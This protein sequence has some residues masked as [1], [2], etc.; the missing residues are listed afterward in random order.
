MD[1]MVERILQEGELDQRLNWGWYQALHNGVISEVVMPAPGVFQPSGRSYDTTFPLDTEAPAADTLDER[2][3]GYPLMAATDTNNP[4]TL[5]R[6]SEE[7]GGIVEVA[8][9]Y[10]HDE[11]GGIVDAIFNQLYADLEA[12]GN[13]HARMIAIA[14][15]I[16]NL[17]VL[18][19]Y[20]DANGRLNVFIL[21][22]HFLMQQ[23]FRPM[24]IGDSPEQ[25]EILRSMGGLFNGG[26]SLEQIATAIRMFQRNGE[27]NFPPPDPDDG[28]IEIG[29]EQDGR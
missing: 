26:Y 29:E 5:Y 8:T 20:T 4:I 1:P 25:R 11:T 21:L 16:R 9:N 14:R 3:A 24:Y 18:H 17:H 15:A 19:P 23:G 28:E 2:I 22:P 12:A 6:R 10:N 13:D 7:R 27:P